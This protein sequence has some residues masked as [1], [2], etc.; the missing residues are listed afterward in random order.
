MDMDI[1]DGWR[2]IAKAKERQKENKMWLL[3]CSIYPNFNKD[4]FITFEEF[5]KKSTKKISTKST[6]DIVKEAK[7]IEKRL[8]KG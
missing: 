2:L 8:K 3:Y 1:I 5:C 4:K 6:A 7:E